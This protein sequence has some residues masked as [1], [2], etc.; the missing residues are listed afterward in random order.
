MGLDHRRSFCARDVD[1][2]IISIKTVFVVTKL[3]DL[4][5]LRDRQKRSPLGK[6]TRSTEGRQNPYCSVP[7]TLEKRVFQEERSGQMCQILSR[8]QTDLTSQR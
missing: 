4:L 6:L 1:S 3:K 5:H 7:K 2:K 8:S